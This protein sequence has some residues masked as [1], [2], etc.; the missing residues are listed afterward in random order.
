MSSV[1]MLP[2][3]SSGHGTILNC[4]VFFWQLGICNWR[5]VNMVKL[6]GPTPRLLVVC[7]KDEVQ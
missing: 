7:L 2:V 4:T 3:T 1:G 6:D 5:K